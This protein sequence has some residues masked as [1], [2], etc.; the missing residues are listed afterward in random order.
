M[1]KRWCDGSC[2]ANLQQA[3]EAAR[4]FHETYER[5]A[6]LFGYETRKESAVPWEDVPEPNRSLMTAVAG[7]VIARL[8]NRPEGREGVVTVYDHENRY[9]GC[10]GVEVWERALPRGVAAM[11]D[12][13][14]PP[15]DVDLRSARVVEFV[16][17]HPRWT[18]PLVYALFRLKY[19]GRSK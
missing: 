18:L 13:W 12:P 8:R 5:L 9:L 4:L 7:E 17:R 2:Y 1:V 14:G 15:R 19:L 3:R 10:M 11:T 6:P 16:R